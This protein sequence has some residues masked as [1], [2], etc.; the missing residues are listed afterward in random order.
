MTK[1]LYTSM[2]E[3]V[4]GV[5][6]KQGELTSRQ[7]KKMYGIGSPSK[8][9]QRLRERGVPVYSIITKDKHGKRVTKYR[10]SF[11][12]DRE[13]VATAYHANPQIFILRED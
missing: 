9:V 4:A 7:L 2:A 13:V 6:W 11:D 3:R 1:K 8:E 5:I 12:F 10:I